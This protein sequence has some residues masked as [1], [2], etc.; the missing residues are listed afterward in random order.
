MIIE[1]VLGEKDSGK[2]AWAENR[3]LEHCGST[4]P[5]YV[6]TLPAT[7]IFSERIDKHQRSRGDAWQVVEIEKSLHEVFRLID[8][9]ASTCGVLLDGLIAY[10]S[11]RVQFAK[12]TGRGLQD[13]VQSLVEEYSEFMLRASVRVG[14]LC[15][16]SSLISRDRRANMSFSEV[17]IIAL[18]LNLELCAV[19]AR[20][21]GLMWL[22]AE[23]RGRTANWEDIGKFCG[24]DL[25]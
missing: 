18:D 9:S 7:L 24:V 6:A 15:V 22:F 2:S 10:L 5:I 8:A 12:A 1:L 14:R 13:E 17:D 23:G 21:A 25:L 3:M 19:T 16:V 11:R 20:C 4:K